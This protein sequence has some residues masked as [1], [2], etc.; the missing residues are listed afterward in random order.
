MAITSRTPEQASPE[1]ILKVNRGH[2]T[3]EK[4]C[5]HVIDWHFDEDRG[6]IRTGNGP[7]NVTRL[8]HFTCGVIQLISKGKSSI[9]QK[10]QQLNRNTRLVF[11]Y[12]RMT[13]NSTHNRSL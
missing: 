2:W 13:S 10:M 5:H 3:I 4:R 1:H 7:E 12:L 11:D 9:S 8:R 6:R